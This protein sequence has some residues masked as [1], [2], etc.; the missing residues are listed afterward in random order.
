MQQQQQSI[1]EARKR[2]LLLLLVIAFA[3]MSLTSASQ[4]VLGFSHV[5]TNT[6]RLSDFSIRSASTSLASVWLNRWQQQRIFGHLRAGS[7]LTTEYRETA[8]SEELSVSAARAMQSHHEHS[9]V[10][11]HHHD[12]TD[13]SVLEVDD[14]SG[15]ADAT[16]SA[17]ALAPV[18]GTPANGLTIPLHT[19]LAKVWAHDF[20]VTLTSRSVLPLLRPP[21]V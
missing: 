7:P 14:G 1:S 11:R 6:V 9:E 16:G 15:N 12:P 19:A 5:H 2:C 18:L 4:N 3:L 8:N 13:S 10:E 21:R 17:S 20:T